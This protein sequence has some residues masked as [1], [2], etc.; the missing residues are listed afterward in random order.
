[1]YH[2][3]VMLAECL[4]ALQIQPNGTYVDL[5]FGGGGHAKA[6][7]EKLQQGRLYAFDQ[8][9]EAEENAKLLDNKQLIFIKSNFRHLKKYLRLHGCTQVDGILAD[10][11]VSSHQIDSAARGFSTRFDGELD[12]RMNRSQELSAKQIVNKYSKEELQ[13]IF[14]MYGEVRNAK[15]LAEGIVQGRNS[16]MINTTQ[17]LKNILNRFAPKFSE[18][19]YQAQVFQALRIE[20]NDELGALEEML[21]QTAEVLKPN[22]RLVVLTYHSLEDRLVKNFI[23]KGKFHGEI[24]KDI[25]GNFSLPLEALNRKPIEASTAEVAQNNRARSAKLRVAIKK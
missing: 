10:L 12:M 15:T 16:K 22:G 23:Q 4:E 20:V 25:Y 19:K 24:E 5:T 2:I 3:P 13:R 17:E 8:D 7:L 1:M 9:N 14:G 6:V 11:G 18:F 21:L